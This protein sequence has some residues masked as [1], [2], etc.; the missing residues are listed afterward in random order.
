MVENFSQSI[1]DKEEVL[2]ISFNN[3]TNFFTVGTNHGF[4]IYTMEPSF[5]RIQKRRIPGGIKLVQMI[6]ESNL[7]LLV[8]TGVSADH[9]S[10]QINVWCEK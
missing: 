10:D 2:H 8:N 9:P 3:M 6:G 4:W 7:L 5:T 1:S